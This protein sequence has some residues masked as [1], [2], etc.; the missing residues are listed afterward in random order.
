MPDRFV[1][2]ITCGQQL[3]NEHSFQYGLW[4]PAHG[5]HT[6]L[7]FSTGI[8]MKHSSEIWSMWT[9]NKKVFFW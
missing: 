6:L 8:S 1:G 3:L 2:C 5:E 4:R 9:E 7:L